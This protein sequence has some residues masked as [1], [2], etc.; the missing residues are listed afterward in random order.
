MTTK[1]TTTTTTSGFD[2]FSTFLGHRHDPRGHAPWHEGAMINNEQFELRCR[3]CG[4]LLAEV[5]EGQLTLQQGNVRA[6]F[7]NGRRTTLICPQPRC[8]R[9]KAGGAATRP[10][11]LRLPGLFRRWEIEPAIEESDEFHVAPAGTTEDGNEL[12][13]VYCHERPLAPGDPR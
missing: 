4:Q 10:T 1:T 11:L 8:R 3:G 12:F 9:A 7:E 2:N 13:V 5:I 6:T